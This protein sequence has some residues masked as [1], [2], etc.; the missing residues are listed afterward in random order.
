MMRCAP[1]WVL[2]LVL[3]CYVCGCSPISRNSL[4]EEKDPHYIEGT[5]RQKAMDEEGAINE[6]ERALQTNPNNSAAHF[7]LGSLYERS[8]DWPSSLYHYTRF[9]KL[10]PNASMASIV[11]SRILAVKRELANSISYVN[12][13]RDTQQIM[14][15]YVRTNTLYLQQIGKLEAELSRRPAYITNYVT[16]FVTVPQ[17]TPKDRSVT[18]STEIVRS[19]QSQP[20]P[21][22]RDPE[23]EEEVRP[24]PRQTRTAAAERRESPRPATR[25]S[26]QARNSAKKE[27][28]APTQRTHTVRPGE[29]LAVVAAKYGISTKKL[30]AA[31]PGSSKG[32]RAGQKLVIP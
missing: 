25:S 26:T 27:P 3:A 11:Q 21:Q 17:F 4:E 24:E 16:N 18:E 12:L 9:L 32:V 5:K 13:S 19:E 2:S 30:A 20:T 6:F 7:Q 23:P 14:E 22:P 29:T 15:A 10:N 1:L 8:K 28:E 31:N